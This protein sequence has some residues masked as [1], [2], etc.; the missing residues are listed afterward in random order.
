MASKKE[1]D[2]AFLAAVDIET[3]NIN[4]NCEYFIDNYG[5]VQDPDSEGGISRFQL[6]PE[7]KRALREIQAHRLNIVLKAR[8]LGLT[9]LCLWYALWC[10]SK[11]VALS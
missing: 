2:A 4:S 5:H 11:I 3:R 1:L 9:W 10:T 8:Q 7:Q 6:W